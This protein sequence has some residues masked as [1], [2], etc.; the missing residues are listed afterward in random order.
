MP[1]ISIGLFIVLIFFAIITDLLH[2]RIFNYLTI[3]GLIGGVLANIYIHGT[4]GI[5]ISLCGAMLGI[6]L[7]FP[8]FATRLLGAG[9]VK[10]LGAIGA[11]LG[12]RMVFSAAI[13]TV[14]VGAIMSIFI[15]T[16]KGRII[17]VFKNAFWAVYSLINPNLSFEVPK[18]ES[19]H[20]TPFAIP[21]AI[22]GILA[23]NYDFLEC[24]LFSN[25]IK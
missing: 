4:Y 15:L 22:G 25:M 13:Y 2:R 9:D 24:L 17:G 10:L 8:L 6:S 14:V 7:Y 21:I 3:C 18:I 5:V 16:Y 19:C 12:P 23:I 1:V 20:K 11:I